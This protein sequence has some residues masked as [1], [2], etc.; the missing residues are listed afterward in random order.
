MLSHKLLGPFSQYSKT[1]S[2]NCI[3]ATVTRHHYRF[4]QD[5]Q[6][7]LKTN[8]MQECNHFQQLARGARKYHFFQHSPTPFRDP[9][10]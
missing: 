2:V 7:L 4:Q 10:I 3:I 1:A 6:T 8:G 5:F 9:S